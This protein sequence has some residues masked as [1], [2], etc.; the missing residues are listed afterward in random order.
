MRRAGCSR[1][2]HPFATRCKH[3]V[4]LACVKHA[5]SVRPEPGSNSPLNDCCQAAPK[6]GPGNQKPNHE[7][8][9]AVSVRRGPE[10]RLDGGL[11][12]VNALAFSTLLSSQETDAHHREELSSPSGAT[13]KPYSRVSFVSTSFPEAFREVA[14]PTRQ[15]LQTPRVSL[16]Q[17]GGRCGR[18]RDL[19]K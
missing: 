3:L 17:P 2:T 13:L 10:T 9:M 18:T 19:R 12:I 16:R 14:K 6:D 4:R 8:Y 11:Y 1:V 7:R 15:S 5:A